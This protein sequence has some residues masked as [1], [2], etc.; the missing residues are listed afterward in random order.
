MTT[1]AGQFY[2]DFFNKTEALLAE[3]QRLLLSID[4]KYQEHDALDP[5]L[6][7]GDSTQ[8]D[9]VMC[10]YKDMTEITY[11]LEGLLDEM[12]ENKIAFN[13]HIDSL[14]SAKDILTLEIDGLLGTEKST[15]VS[16]MLNRYL[17]KM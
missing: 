8:A 7:T 2:K 9:A 5:N 12:L 16:L 1:D 11:L 17:K 13:K 15:T 14:S 6:P 3:V 10:S 4:I